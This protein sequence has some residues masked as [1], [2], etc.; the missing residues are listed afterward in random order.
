MFFVFTKCG[1]PNG[2]QCISDV[3]DIYISDFV[4]NISKADTVS[5]DLLEKYIPSVGLNQNKTLLTTCSTAP[6][7]EE[8]RK[9]LL[10]HV[11]YF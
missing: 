3:S 4:F 10:K 7:V 6:N 9:C 11:S 1:A 2:T 8:R 5:V